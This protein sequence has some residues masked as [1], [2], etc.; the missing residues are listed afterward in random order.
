VFEGDMR[1]G[2][3]EYAETRQQ[4]LT[5][6]GL[7]QG[8]PRERELMRIN[9]S[10]EIPAGVQEDHEA[11]QHREDL[12]RLVPLERRPPLRLPCLP[13][14]L[15]DPLWCVHVTPAAART[16][17]ANTQVLKPPLFKP[18]PALHLWWH[19]ARH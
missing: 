7:V 3:E 17:R 10:P 2:C 18:V 1:A 13:T 19:N 14:L 4:E 16:A 15:Y 6:G 11:Q 12:E 5:P 9:R 8:L